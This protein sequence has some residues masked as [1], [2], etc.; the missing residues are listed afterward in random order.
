MK[1]ILSLILLMSLSLSAEVV[2]ELDGYFFSPR[3]VALGMAGTADK[4]TDIFVSQYGLAGLKDFGLALSGYQFFTDTDYLNA[5][6]Y[7]PL[8]SVGI[9]LGYRLRSVPDV[10]VTLPDIIGANGRPDPSRLAHLTYQQSTFYLA[11][12]IPL[13]SM[14][15]LGLAYKSYSI[16]NDYAALS[17]LS[18]RGNNLDAGLLAKLGKVWSVSLLGRNVL[19]GQGV[20]GALVWGNDSVERPLQS[21]VLGNKLALADEK[22]LY[23]LDVEQYADDYYPALWRT[24]AEF[25]LSD[26]LTLRWGLRQYTVLT[27]EESQ[28]ISVAGSGGLRLTPRRGWH[29]DYAYY[30]GDN[31]TLAAMHYA[32]L[33]VNLAAVSP[34]QPE[35]P[36]SKE[37]RAAVGVDNVSASP[38][39]PA[40]GCSFPD[41]QES[42]AA[43]RDKDLTYLVFT[44]EWRQNFI[45]TRLGL[46]EFAPY[47]VQTLDLVLPDELNE[48]VEP[49]DVLYFYNLL[50]GPTEGVFTITRFGRFTLGHLAE[51][52]ARVEGYGAALDASPDPQEQ[53]VAVLAAGGQYSA[54]DFEPRA[55][56]ITLA[57]AESLLLRTTRARHRLA[58]QYGAAPLAWLDR[59]EQNQGRLALRF[60]NTECLS[61]Y[62]WVSGGQNFAA[63]LNAEGQAVVWITPDSSAPLRIT[64]YD[65][66][67]KAWHFTVNWRRR[68][69]ENADSIARP[70]AGA[71]AS[72]RQPPPDEVR[73]QT[74]IAIVLDKEY[75]GRPSQTDGGQSQSRATTIKPAPPPQ[76]KP[77]V[78]AKKRRLN[79]AY[80]PVEIKFSPA[81]P[82]PGQVLLI[83]AKYDSAKIRKVSALIKGQQ[84][85]LRRAAGGVWQRQYNLPPGHQTLYIKIFCEDAQGNLS[86]TEKVLT[87]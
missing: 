62:S 74:V 64:A 73:V 20:N 67:A 43:I 4:A 80:Y 15:D 83:T 5:A 78:P 11:L 81:R 27:G 13:G 46:E 50:G 76:L 48:A 33:A 65:K 9:G 8:G 49:V 85:P 17:K 7:F 21:V 84:I 19:S 58:E 41:W 23:F 2:T 3:T 59:A 60:Y 77:P 55:G 82:R 37:E 40:G 47:A 66:L 68:T 72:V 30:T 1:K 56:E 12:G 42:C 63:S 69:A 32:G 31:Q 34:P 39:R 25:V 38:S 24:G 54:A 86:M 16:G 36:T 18:A 10:L 35:E 70:L 79:K 52:L 26:Y 61:G 14:F 6:V 28:R 51:I 75:A 87:Y 29:L 57:K 45:N 22:V 44:P 71:E 53:A